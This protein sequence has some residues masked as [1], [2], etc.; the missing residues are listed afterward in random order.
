MHLVATKNR[1]HGKMGGWGF[2]L[3]II[4]PENSS[5]IRATQ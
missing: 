2:L 1:V 4:K 3:S 5:Q